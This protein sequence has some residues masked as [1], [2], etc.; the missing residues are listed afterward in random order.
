MNI[1]LCPSETFY[2]KLSDVT[3][4]FVVPNSEIALT[5]QPL[6][7]ITTRRG[8][9]GDGLEVGLPADQQGALPLRQDIYIVMELH[10]ASSEHESLIDA[11]SLLF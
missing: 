11:S 7:D 1:N 2:D 4:R 6:L 10:W 9:D 3:Y 5:E 8:S